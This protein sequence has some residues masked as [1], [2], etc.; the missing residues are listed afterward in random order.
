MLVLVPR[1]QVDAVA[2]TAGLEQP[3]DLGVVGGGELE[4]GHPHVGMRE[5]EDPSHHVCTVAK[6]WF[7]A[8]S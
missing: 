2:V 6:R 7:T 4:V 3:D 5:P 8:P 1:L